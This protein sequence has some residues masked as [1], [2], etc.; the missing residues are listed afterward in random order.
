[1]HILCVKLFLQIYPINAFNSVPADHTF[2]LTQNFR[3]GPEIAFAVNVIL[4]EQRCPEQKS[5]VAGRK[6]DFI[7][8]GSCEIDPKLEEFR[9]V[10]IIGQSVNKLLCEVDKLV[11][12]ADESNRPTA[13]LVGGLE[14]YDLDD[15]L[16][17]YYLIKGENDKLK[18]WKTLLDVDFFQELYTEENKGIQPSSN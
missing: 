13:A 5:L 10:A 4:S 14:S 16:D 15:Y 3:F 7:L 6:R 17:I 9:P 1:M 2:Y 11:C 18:K 8:L 12:D